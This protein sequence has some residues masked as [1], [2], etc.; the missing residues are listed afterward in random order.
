MSS[1]LFLSCAACGIFVSFNQRL[2]KFLYSVTCILFMGIIFVV[3][4]FFFILCLS[5]S[6]YLNLCFSYYFSTASPASSSLGSS[7]SSLISFLPQKC[8]MWIPH[9][10]IFLLLSQFN[11]VSPQRHLHPL[12]WDHLCRL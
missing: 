7:L 2:I 11:K 8:C 10:G 12:H 9:C 6:L 1:F 3:F 4:D 5:L